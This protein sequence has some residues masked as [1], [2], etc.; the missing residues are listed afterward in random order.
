MIREHTHALDVSLKGIRMVVLRR[1]MKRISGRGFPLLLPLYLSLAIPEPLQAASILGDIKLDHFG[2]RTTGSKVAYFTANPGASVGVYNAATN[3][4]AYTTTNITSKGTDT[5]SPLISGDT[6]WWVDFSPFTTAGTYYL[7]STALNEQSYNFNISDSVYQAP[8]TATLKALY[9]QRCGTAKPAAY[10]GVWADSSAC[11]LQDKTCGPAPG[12][13]F[14]MAYGTLDLS[15]GWHDAGDYNKYIGSTPSGACNSW[16]GDDGATLH[17]LLSAYEWNPALFPDGQSNIPESGNGIPDLL[18][19]C[20]WETDWYLKMQMTDKHVLSVVHLTNYTSGSPPSTDTTTRYYYPPNPA[21]EAQFVAVLSHAARVMSTV[22]GL[23]SYAVTLQGAA[24]ATWTTFVQSA[25]ASDPKFWAAAEIYRMEMAL[26]GSAS[27]AS[28][29][30][31]IVDNYQTW[32]TYWMNMNDVANYGIYAYAQAPGATASV[33]A[34]MKTAIGNQVNYVFSFSDLYNSAMAATDYYWSSNQVKSEYAQSLLW[35]ARLG[36]TGSYTSAQCLQHA[37]DFLHYLNGSNPMNMTY[38]TNA[39]ALGA[40]HGVWRVYHAWFGAYTTP[41]SNTNFI[42]MPASDTDPL[43]PYYSGT[44]NYG[45]TDTANSTYGPPPGIVPDGPTYQYY[46]LGG[47]SIPP[48]LAGGAE[49]PYEKIYRDWDY[50]D[51]TGAQTV[52]WIV[53]ETGIYYISS[54]TILAS[55]FVYSLSSASTPTVTP[56]ATRTVTLTATPS[57]TSTPS[58]VFT[59]TQTLTPSF[60]STRTIPPTITNTPLLSFTPTDSMT[61]TPTPTG[62]PSPVMTV[63]LTPSPFFTFTQTLTPS[64]A[65]TRTL[66]PSITQTILPASG[67]IIGPPYPNPVLGAGPVSIQIQA[68]AGSTVEWGVFTTAFRKVL[69]RSNPIPGNNTALVWNLEDGWGTPVASG[70][71]YLRL[72]ISGPVKA[73]KI[74][75]ILVLR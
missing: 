2:Y 55:A 51:P 16:G 41:F 38:M 19:E 44:D 28:A 73:T 70:L 24:E 42:G 54:Y 11:H 50:S 47:K 65:S 36:A 7:L 14:P 23:A 49:P 43:Y 34:S 29:A 63:T 12:C 61:P 10:A 74:L 13:T 30:Q 8:M 9:Y 53:N 46:T 75:K 62:T 64:P 58:S 59:F 1:P 68:P 69:D 4:L 60:T 32:S 52:P 18:D 20:K 15:G 17:Y 71:Y 33:V 21:G 66:T 5:G 39:A 72:Q 37:E 67:V 40:S 6:V 25:T 56:T 48:L 57:S 31:S 3:A 26:G 22:P 45:V 35:G 27:I